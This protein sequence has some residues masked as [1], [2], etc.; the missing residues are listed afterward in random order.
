MYDALDEYHVSQVPDDVWSRLLDAKGGVHA[1]EIGHNSYV[2][3]KKMELAT[4]DHRGF[5]R[6]TSQGRYYAQ[7]VT[8]P[9]F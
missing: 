1:T 3:M 2:S 8:A 6:L 5:V 4:Q 7:L 9:P